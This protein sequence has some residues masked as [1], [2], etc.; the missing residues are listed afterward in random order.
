MAEQWIDISTSL[1]NGMVVWPGDPVLQISRV[2]TI[3]K[4]SE[5]NLSK[6]TMSAHAGTHIDAP[7]HFFPDGKTVDR[8]PLSAF[9]GPARVIEIK[10]PVSIGYQE[11]IRQKIRRGERILFKTINSQRCWKDNKFYKDFVYI[12]LEAAEYLAAKKP[13]LVGVDYLSVGGFYEN[14][15][16]IHQTLLKSG[17]WIIEG[18]NFSGIKPGKYE[19]VCLPLKLIDTDGAPARAVLR[20]K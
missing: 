1:K 4:R 7:F 15:A 16:I 3:G 11:L 2:K 19:F 12:S 6:I 10:D 5:C 14:G 17:I 9:I 18:L 8:L 20:K 13:A